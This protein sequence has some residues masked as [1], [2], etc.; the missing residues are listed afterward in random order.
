MKKVILLLIFIIVSVYSFALDFSVYP[1]RF[2]VDLKRP[3]VEEVYIENDRDTTLKVEIFPEEDKIFG[4]EFNLNSNIMIYPKVVYIKPR[5]R[6]IVRFKVKPLKQDGE[7]KSYITFKQVSDR[8]DKEEQESEI[9]SQ[10]AILAELS[11]PIYGRGENI[12]ESGKVENVNL[13]RE[14]DIVYLKADISV[15]GNSS[16]KLDYELYYSEDNRKYEGSFGVTPRK[17]RESLNSMIRIDKNLEGKKAT[18]LIKDKQGKIYY[19][20]SQII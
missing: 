17:G 4:S 8:D 9:H 19:K 11:I 16:L 3:T 12:V 18:I 1:T 7:Y 5:D 15:E 20:K 13:I 2:I 10:I 6:Q 14:K